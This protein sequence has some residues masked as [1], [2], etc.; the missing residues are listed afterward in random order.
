MEGTS[1]IQPEPSYP[2]EA[3]EGIILVHLFRVDQKYSYEEITYLP[4]RYGL[5]ISFDE[6]K[7]IC[8]KLGEERKLIVK[9]LP[10]RLD[11]KM[12]P[13][14][15][16]YAGDIVEMH[17]KSVEKIPFQQL[18]HLLEEKEL[19]HDFEVIIE[20]NLESAT[21]NYTPKGKF[22]E[23][24]IRIVRNRH[25]F[26]SVFA[27]PK[28]N[29]RGRTSFNFILEVFSDWVNQVISLEKKPATQPLKVRDPVVF[30]VGSFW[31]GD[32]QTERFL[33][34]NIW[35]NAKEEGNENIINEVRPGDTFVLK[36][37]FA[38]DK[39]SYFRIKGI[40]KVAEQKSQDIFLV[41]WTVKD[42]LLDIENL[43]FYRKTIEQ[44]KQDDW[45]IIEDRLRQDFT[46]NSNVKL[47]LDSVSDMDLLGRAPF[48]K[49]MADYISRLWADQTEQAYTIH[50]SGEWGSG[51]SNILKFLTTDLENRNWY[52]L[53][54]NAWE[55]QHIETPWW[56]FTNKI[57]KQMLSKLKGWSRARFWFKEFWW[58]LFV[59][60]QLSW[61]SFI[62]IALVASLLIYLTE[63]KNLI[64]GELSNTL[65]LIGSIISVGGSVW[66][67]FKG[68][69]G[70][71][72]PASDES[73][74]NFQK[75]INDPID[76]VKTHFQSMVKF[77]G[78]NTAIFIDDID[79]CTSKNVVK[80][81]EG[82][83]TIFKSTK[84]LYV[85]AGDAN[86]V[87]R[88]FEIEYQNFVT[89]F[90]KPGHSLG[91]FFVEKVF[92]MSVKIPVIASETLKSF[93]KRTLNP[94]N[95]LNTISKPVEH[96]LDDLKNA[97]NEAEIE[98]ALKR[99][100]GTDQE[101]AAIKA[102]VE[103]LSSME[104]MKD[105]EHELEAY[106]DLL[107][108]NVRSVK[109]FINNYA[110]SRQTLLLQRV[111]FTD[112]PMESLVRWLIVGARYPM[113]A[114]ELSNNPTLFNNG[115]SEF[116]HIIVSAAFQSLTKGFLDADKLRLIVGKP[117]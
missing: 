70:S 113:L 37:T 69:S 81:L 27:N 95:E 53:Q 110:I 12:L 77:S 97:R 84:V 43:G 56:I 63:F 80:L 101:Q 91:N 93:L 47:Q 54:Y 42:I 103:L 76:T 32:D 112:V 25:I 61:I 75:N 3:I 35:E 2:L 22:S 40:G 33:N 65:T 6:F 51:K 21:I 107:P 11:A 20:E 38:R 89:D 59:I 109:R 98:S 115:E 102:A 52:V 85:F 87:R 67:L 30:A 96:I 39:I 100:R 49:A 31:G 111:S 104:T 23:Y 45:K 44:L 48:V 114:E 24:Y 50:L 68:I 116:Q 78:K 28:V 94:L 79:R 4:S 62:V 5:D 83:Q 18:S 16:A 29:L 71:L 99:Y 86:W 88:C 13:A 58:R 14:G 117:N 26:Y 17:S 64:H 105:L 34:E 90:K 55:Y 46:R 72:L 82:I 8:A 108:A 15:S 60:N 36:S 9:E 1:S 7:Q 106:Y 66:L 41:D 92:Q 57:Y 19:T 73:A 74:Q 10:D